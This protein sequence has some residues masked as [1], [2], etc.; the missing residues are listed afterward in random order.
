MRQQITE[1]SGLK[2]AQ[3]LDS[4]MDLSMKVFEGETF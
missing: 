3:P 4:Q 1:S 2:M